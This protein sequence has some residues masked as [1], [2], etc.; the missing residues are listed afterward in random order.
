[1]SSIS[2]E[3]SDRKTKLAA[4]L[5]VF[6]GLGYEYGHY[7][8]LTV[9]DPGD[10]ERY[11]VNPLAVAFGRTSVSDLVLVDA[12]GTVLDGN[13]Q[14]GGFVGQHEIHRARPDAVAV[15]HVHSPY[16]Q[17]W[18]SR[19]RPFEPLNTD[20]AVIDSVQAVHDPLDSANWIEGVAPTRAQSLGPHAK[21][22][23][24]RGHGVVTLGRSVEEAAF[25]HIA[26]ERAAHANLTLAATGGGERL[27]DD[28]RDRWQIT[29]EKAE[30]HYRPYLQQVLHDQPELLA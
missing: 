3:R 7:G 25:L 22:L 4:T 16:A 30:R 12:E 18:A 6:A 8:H 14:I 17:I 20:S 13:A 11:W 26:A 15:F 27:P 2:Q 5:R 24:Q 28:I 1:M 9:R 29:A 23:I 10:E 21:I 19:P